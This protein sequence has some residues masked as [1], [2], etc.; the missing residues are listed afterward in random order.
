M[1]LASVRSLA[2][3]VATSGTLMP[4]ERLAGSATFRVFRRGVTSTPRSSGLM[5]SSGFFLA[6]M[7]FGRVT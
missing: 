4:A 7:M 1:T 2:T 3:R 6:Y 5:V